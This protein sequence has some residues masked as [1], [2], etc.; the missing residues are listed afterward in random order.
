M[1]SIKYKGAVYVEAA[2]HER[3]QNGTHWNETKK[4]CVKIPAALGRRVEHAKSLSTTAHATTEDA[5]KFPDKNKDLSTDAY[6]AKHYH[7][8]KATDEHVAAGKA[9]L[10]VSKTARR[11]GFNE[12]ADTHEAASK[13]HYEKYKDHVRTIAKMDYGDNYKYNEPK[14]PE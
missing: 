8:Q 10:G 4:K 12:L 11:L 9:N 2:D 7:H 1:K 6:W 5:K 13:D 14:F 3:C